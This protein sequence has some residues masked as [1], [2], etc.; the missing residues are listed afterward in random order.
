MLEAMEIALPAKTLTAK[1]IIQGG[2]YFCAIKNMG[3]G[4]RCVFETVTKYHFTR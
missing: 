1:Q 2:L 3:I 4:K